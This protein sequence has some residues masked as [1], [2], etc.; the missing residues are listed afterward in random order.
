MLCRMLSAIAI[1]TA[2][3]FGALGAP[4]AA[5]AQRGD[6]QTL[7]FTQDGLARSFILYKPAGPAALKGPRPLVLVIHGGA[8]TARG[9]IRLTKRRWNALADQHGFFVVYPEG[10][11]KMWD[12]GEGPVSARLDQRVD[13]LSYFRNVISA[14]SKAVS[15]DQTRVFATGLSRGAQASLFFWRAIC[16]GRSGR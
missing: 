14:T 9:M 7:A 8:G 12:F 1:C 10:I 2:L 6:A 16:Q 11:D 15:I 13:D 3:L 5:Q 4:G